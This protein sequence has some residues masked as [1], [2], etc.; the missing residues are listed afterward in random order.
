MKNELFSFSILPSVVPADR[1][2]KITIRGKGDYYRF[3]DDVEY[4][5]TVCPREDPDCPTDD[6]L[7]LR[8]YH[9]KPLSVYPKNGVIEFEYFFSNEQEW[10]II[11]SASEKQREHLSKLRVAYKD[12][13]DLTE[14]ERGKVF[15]IYS[16]KD[17]LYKRHVYKG[18]MHVHSS[19]SDGLEPAEI[20]CA[21]Y[22]RE[23][24]DYLAITDHHIYQSSVDAK[25]RFEEFKSGL[26]VF[27]GEEVHNDIAGLIHI[28]NFGGSKSVNDVI[29]S[30]KENIKKQVLEESKKLN[31]GDGQKAEMLAWYQ[32]VTEEIRKCGGISIFAHPFWYVLNCYNCPT[33]TAENVLKR[34]YFDAFEVL[35]GIEPYQNNM[36]T[37]FYNQMRAEGCRIPIVGSTDCHSV[38]EKGV[39][40]FTSAATLCF[41]ESPE[42]IPQA[43]KDLY[44]VEVECIPGQRENVVGPFRLVKYAWFLIRNYFPL[45]ADMCA[46][47]GTAMLAYFNDNAVQL[48]DSIEAIETQITCFDDHFFGRS[49]Q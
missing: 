45:R 20:V 21:S 22:R 8:Q 2:S 47:S 10:D 19:A 38:H 29:L 40:F 28:V 24:Y 46:A 36:Q 23:G 34:G 16:L 27:C 6:A 43:V 5:V 49:V 35:G 32:W 1:T 14:M 42:Q 37:A 17:D 9:R 41:A 44:S 12:F 39:E 26:T 13:W 48:K 15:N 30:D 18:D 33:D 11:V 3:F 7:C 25:K 4:T 31:A